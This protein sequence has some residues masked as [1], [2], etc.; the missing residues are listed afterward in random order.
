MRIEVDVDITTLFKISDT[1]YTRE[2]TL[3]EIEN[4][5]RDK[6]RSVT[7]MV[8]EGGTEP[9]P[10]LATFKLRGIRFTPED[11]TEV[12]SDGGSGC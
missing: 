7:I 12:S 11:R 2:M 1:G 4:W 10:V 9:K 8:K 6:L 3:P 5:A